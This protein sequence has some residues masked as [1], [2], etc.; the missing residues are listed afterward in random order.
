MI[1]YIDSDYKCHS[2]DPDGIY[3]AFNVSFFDLKC[4]E[5]IEGYRYIP[6]GETWLDQNG[7]ENTGEAIFP[8]KDWN[9]LYEAQCEY[10]RT[11]VG[12][13]SRI[14]TEIERLIKPE[15][16][17]GTMDTIAEVRKQAILKRINELLA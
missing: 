16:V 3:R 6:T 8:W 14:F 1:I 9:E 13:Y 7:V 10:E 11:L 17:S 2:T 5:F 4:P 15:P 12:E